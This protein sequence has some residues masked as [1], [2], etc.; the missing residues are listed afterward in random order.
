MKRL[1]L[2]AVA[3]FLSACGG[4]DNTNTATD[5]TGNFVG[6]WTGTLS[7]TV[8]TQT[9]TQAFTA[10]V[11]VGAARNSLDFAGS[12]A[13]Q[14]TADS[15]THVTITPKTCPA[16]SS[17]GCTTVF[18]VASGSFTKNGSTAVLLYSGQVTIS[19]PSTC[20]PGTYAY[21]ATTNSLTK[22]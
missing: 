16:Q 10:T 18:N 22:Q 20:A 1:A 17:G 6:N 7:V 3:A 13:L 2:L 21:S 14:G 15:A 8:D 19:G 9:Q 4:S 5:Y 12:C 11:T